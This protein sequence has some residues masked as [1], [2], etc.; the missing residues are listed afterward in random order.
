LKTLRPCSSAMAA[1]VCQQVVG[2]KGGGGR[3]EGKREEKKDCEIK[4]EKMKMKR[5]DLLEKLK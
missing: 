1:G 3:R 4:R 5:N 2:R